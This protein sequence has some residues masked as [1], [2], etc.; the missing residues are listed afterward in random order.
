MS[1][2]ICPCCS[3]TLLRH[4]RHTGVYW[5]CSRCHEE[6]PD[7]S[8]NPIEKEKDKEIVPLSS[9]KELPNFKFNYICWINRK[10]LL[11]VASSA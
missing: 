7:L 4:I 5:Y 8:L 1:N 6:M 3:S 10:N 2:V 9:V 11:K